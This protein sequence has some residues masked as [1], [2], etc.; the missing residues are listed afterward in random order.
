[1][2]HPDFTESDLDR[3]EAYLL[4][5]ERVDSTL[6]PDAVQGLLCAVVSA[7]APIAPETW[8]PAALGADHRFASEAEAAEISD[9]LLRFRDDT[10]RQLNAG[11]GFDFILYGAEDDNDMDLWCEGYLEGVELADPSWDE[12]SDPA[13]VDEMLFPFL[14][15]S[16]R[17]REAMLERGEPE[18]SIEDE[19]R[20]LAEFREGLADDVIAIRSFWF[21][22]S[23]PPTVRREAPKVGRNDPCPCG[24][25]KKHKNCCGAGA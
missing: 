8:I 3:L 2:A 14:A 1:M 15:L 12:A 20:M 22:K 13:D 19:R 10:A 7:P 5:P 25:G 17:L 23:I 9:L 4:A 24:S 6:P 18:M 16:G 11:E 21:E